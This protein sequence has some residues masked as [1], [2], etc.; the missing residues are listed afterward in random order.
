MFSYT[1]KEKLWQLILAQRVPKGHGLAIDWRM[2]QELSWPI[3][4]MFSETKLEQSLLSPLHIPCNY[5]R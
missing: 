2:Q 4:S 5:S 3:H 1:V